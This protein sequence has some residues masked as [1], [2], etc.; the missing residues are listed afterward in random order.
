MP[1]MYLDGRMSPLHTKDP[2]SFSQQPK[3]RT[4]GTQNCNS[5]YSID[6]SERIGAEDHPLTQLGHIRYYV[7][8]KTS[9]VFT[10]YVIIKAF[11]LLINW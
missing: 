5:W 10:W 8:K 4:S 1:G 11:Y 3:I 9:N 7:K 6:G 2:D